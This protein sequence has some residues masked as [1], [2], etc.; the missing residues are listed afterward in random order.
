[1]QMKLLGIITVDFD[2]T[3]EILVIYAAFTKYFSR[4]GNTMRQ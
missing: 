3:G 4:S 1:M 2:I